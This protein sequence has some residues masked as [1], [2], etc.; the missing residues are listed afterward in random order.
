MT[1]LKSKIQTLTKNIGAF[2]KSRPE[3]WLLLYW[4]IH[5]VIYMILN[6]LT[7]SMNYHIMYSPTDDKIPFIEY[8]VLP[9]DLW[10]FY[11]AAVLIYFLWKNKKDYLR[12]SF[13]LITG[14]A[15]STLICFIY[16]SM[17]ELRP[18]VFERQNICV[19]LVKMLYETDEPAV[20]F[21]SMHVLVSCLLAV[22]LWTAEC[23]KGKTAARIA[24]TVLSV[25][26]CM[27]TVFIKQHSILDV[28][29]ALI[30]FVPICL[31]T[32]LFSRKARRRSK[33][34]AI[35]R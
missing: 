31:V 4:P 6:K 1:T 34:A 35:S 17:H 32:Y 18:V 27:A 13:M 2:L 7:P 3:S 12:T 5:T 10:F 14:M 23:M 30:L 8:F 16:P 15:V 22:S 26:I 25:L 20:L 28:Y 11:I 29:F 24:G 19:E 9:Y 33:D 21:P